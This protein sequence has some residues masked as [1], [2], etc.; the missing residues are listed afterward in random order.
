MKKRGLSDVVTTVLIILLAI[1]AIVIVWFFVRGFLL[2]QD[3]YIEF[4]SNLEIKKAELLNSN[5]IKVNVKAL[6]KDVDKLRFVIYDSFGNT[7][8]IDLQ[9]SSIKQFQQKEFTLE[10]FELE[11]ELVKIEVYSIY[12]ENGEEVVEKV[13]AGK[14]LI[15]GEENSGNGGEGG[16]SGDEDS[17]NDDGDSLT[18][19]ALL[20]CN[21]SDLED[22]FCSDVCAGLFVQST[23][24]WYASSGKCTVDLSMGPGPNYNNVFQDRVCDSYFGDDKIGDCSQIVRADFTF[25]EEY[26]IIC[27]SYSR[28]RR[29]IVSSD[30]LC[31][32]SNCPSDYNGIVNFNNKFFTGLE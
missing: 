16:D 23:S 6:R 26:D 15:F 2:K 28:E 18:E 29:Q 12:I 31:S 8:V 3:F 14:D 9:D 20:G 13:G 4:D 24:G 25:N 17:G 1:A 27:P 5:E 7:E 10:I 21:P 30:C 19:I 22:I 32:G 11:G